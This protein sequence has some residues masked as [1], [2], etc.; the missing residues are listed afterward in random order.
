M[1]EHR[2]SGWC[3]G[4]GFP[5]FDIGGEQNWQGRDFVV[6]DERYGSHDGRGSPRPH[7]A[8]RPRVNYASQRDSTTTRQPQRPCAYVLAWN[9]TET[10]FLELIVEPPGFEFY[11]C[12][13][14][15]SLQKAYTM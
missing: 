7:A 5:T 4:Q 13:S 15:I 12:F 1:L 11:F 6:R 3:A 10:L 2:E 8:V 14:M 9:S